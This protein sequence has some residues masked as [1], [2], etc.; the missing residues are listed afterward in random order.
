[1][2]NDVKTFFDQRCGFKTLEE[3]D[4]YMSQFGEDEAYVLEL[5]QQYEEYLKEIENRSDDDVI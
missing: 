4:D 2:R 3:L 5:E 1:M